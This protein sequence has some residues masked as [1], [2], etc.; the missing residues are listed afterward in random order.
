MKK[1]LQN[2]LL[3]LLLLSPLQANIYHVVICWLKEPKNELHKTKLIEA[4]KQLKT[5]E[6][7]ESIQIGSM[8]PSKREVVDSSY[9]M[10]IIFEFKNKEAMKK[11]ASNPL[12]K[13]ALKEVLAPLTSKVIIYDFES[14][15][16]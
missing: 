13:K 4:T 11:Y 6:G 12:H 3:A 7:I 5:I 1:L 2:T 15:A 9:D 14:I 16:L 8:L 10:G